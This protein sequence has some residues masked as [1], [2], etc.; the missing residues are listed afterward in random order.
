[1]KIDDE[2]VDKLAVLAKLEFNDEA[3]EGIKEDL[4]RML[5]FID[6]LNELDTTGIEPLIYMSDETNVMRADEAK[7]D[8]THEE[9][10]KNAPDRDSDYIRVHKVIGN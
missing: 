3:K 4:N 10:L 9:A 6:K 7:I 8:I 2:M 1:M 5:D